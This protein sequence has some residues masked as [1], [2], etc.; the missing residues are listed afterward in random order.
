MVDAAKDGAWG[1]SKA[2]YVDKTSPLYGRLRPWVFQHDEVIASLWY[3]ADPVGATKAVEMARIMKDAMK[4]AI[5]DL[6]IGADPALSRRWPPGARTVWKGG[7]LVPCDDQGRADG[8]DGVL[9]VRTAP[10]ALSCGHARPRHHAR[11]SL[12]RP[13]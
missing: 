2:A 11:G 1:V 13:P 5:P 3:D 6:P 4:D 12:Y 7:V 8:G 9:S 10:R